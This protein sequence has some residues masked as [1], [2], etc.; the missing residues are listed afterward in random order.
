MKW[1]LRLILPDK[2]FK[3]SALVGGCGALLVI[4]GLILPFAWLT[5]IGLWFGLPLLALGLAGAFGL[6]TLVIIKEYK[7]DNA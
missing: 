6:A 7:R 3:A 2:W 5:N 1:L 4:C